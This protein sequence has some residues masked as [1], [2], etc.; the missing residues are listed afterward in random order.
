[1]GEDFLRALSNLRKKICNI[2]VWNNKKS[3]ALVFD[4][5]KFLA[6]SN[7]KKYMIFPPNWSKH[8]LNST[9]SIFLYDFKYCLCS[10]E[11]TKRVYVVFMLTKR[12][13]GDIF[14]KNFF[15]VLL[16]FVVQERHNV[17]EIPGNYVPITFLI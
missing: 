15:L 3:F 10:K 11:K 16:F 13:F 2:E 8:T 12:T 6:H 1:M 7:T 5:K 9:G 17:R 4:K 14:V